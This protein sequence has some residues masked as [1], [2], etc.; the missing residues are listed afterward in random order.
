MENGKGNAFIFCLST[1]PD[2]A[3][4]QI[5]SHSHKHSYTDS[6]EATMP[7]GSN[8]GVSI[9]LKDTL[10]IGAGDWTTLWF[11]DDVALPCEPQLLSKGRETKTVR[12]C[13]HWSPTERPFKPSQCCCVRA[14]ASTNVC[15]FCCSTS[16]SDCLLNFNHIFKCLL[17]IFHP[18]LI[19]AMEHCDLWRFNGS[20]YAGVQDFEIDKGKPI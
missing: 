6:C 5:A 19:A 7:I 18:G 11:K 13:N 16:S 9:L 8:L 3:L 2:K 12:N 4:L 10:T 15:V 20:C 1:L 14:W 17:V